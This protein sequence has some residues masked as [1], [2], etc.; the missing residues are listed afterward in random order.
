MIIE[1]DVYWRLYGKGPGSVH[2]AETEKLLDDPQFNY[3]K[4]DIYTQ[5]HLPK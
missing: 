1:K 3:Y 2:F 4:N 5:R